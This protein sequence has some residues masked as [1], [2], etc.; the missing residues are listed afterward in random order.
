MVDPFVYLLFFSTHT[1]STI[2]PDLT[3][4]YGL[5]FAFYFN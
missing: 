3:F 2:E 5:T 4:H 1:S